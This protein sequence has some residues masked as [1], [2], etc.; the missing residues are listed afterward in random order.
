MTLSEY[1][2]RESRPQRPQLVD[3]ISTVGDN[4]WEVVAAFKRRTLDV[5][6]HESSQV[7]VS[8]MWYHPDPTFLSSHPVP[9]L[10]PDYHHGECFKEVSFVRIPG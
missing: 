2:K 10:E 4:R 7:H 1:R 3:I 5:D 6:L 8:G 9:G